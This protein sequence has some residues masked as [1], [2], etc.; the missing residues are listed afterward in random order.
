MWQFN[1]PLPQEFAIQDKKTD[2]RG[3]GGGVGAGA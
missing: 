1:Y 3:R 2:A